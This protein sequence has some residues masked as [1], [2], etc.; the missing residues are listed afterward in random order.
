MRILYHYRTLADGAEGI[1]ITSIIAA[2]RSLGHDVEV[3]AVTKSSSGGSG[4]AAAA[5][6][7]RNLLPGAAFELASTALNAAEYMTV[8][9][10]IAQFKPDLI[11]AR[12]ARLAIGAIAAA[13]HAGV[14]TVL[15]VNSLFTQ[16]EYHDF[17]PMSLKRLATMVERR[18]LRLATLVYAVSTPLANQVLNLSGRP[19]LVVPNGADPVKFDVRKTHP[20][21][22]RERHGVTGK[23]TVGWSGIIRDWHG[24]D[25]LLE[26]VVAVPNAHL[27]VVGDGPARGAL[28]EQA[29]RMG[30]TDRL[31]ITGRVP[32]A[33]MPDHIAAMDIAVVSDDRTGVA[34]PMKLL[35]YMAMSRP[36]VAP[37][38]ANIADVIRDGEDGVLFTREDPDGMRHALARLV[39]D[40][41]LRQRLGAAARHRIE[42]DRNWVAIAAHV[43]ESVRA[44]DQ[45]GGRA[46]SGIPYASSI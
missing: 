7:I 3:S 31:S 16:G 39:Q 36:V 35:E 20:E 13:R 4:R 24:L 43:L 14:P 40:A 27:L 18:V 37:R 9:R 5:D 19:A 2:L 30:V 12:H 29:R 33:E 25:R 28:E 44:A 45:G 10:Q 41:A 32:H 6:R 23:V 17:E 22:V 11:Y 26:S 42:E 34:S 15:E 46:R 8:R 1:H 21:T 38:L